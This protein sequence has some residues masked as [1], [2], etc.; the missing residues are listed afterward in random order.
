MHSR[1]GTRVA[2]AIKVCKEKIKRK[3]E[4]DNRTK[5]IREEIKRLYSKGGV[6]H[7]QLADKY[8]FE[9]SYVSHIIRG[10]YD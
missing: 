1:R 3:S 2:W 6:T 10:K 8:G 9:R 7:Q 5:E 4:A